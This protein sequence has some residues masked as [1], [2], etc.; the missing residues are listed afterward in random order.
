MVRPRRSGIAGL[1]SDRLACAST[2]H[3]RVKFGQW[4]SSTCQ[5]T[6]SRYS[7]G[8]VLSPSS[9]IILAK[10]VECFLA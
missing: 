9:S 4:V 5:G 1:A 10:K 7:S 3:N 6:K 2:L 8:V